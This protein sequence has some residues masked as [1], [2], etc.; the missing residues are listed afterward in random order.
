MGKKGGGRVRIKQV[1]PKNAMAPMNPMQEFM[2]IPPDE[3]IQIPP[4]MD[5]SITNIWPPSPFQLFSASA[6]SSFQYD[7]FACIWPT[8]IDVTK[9][10]KEGRRIRKEEAVDTPTVSDISEVLQGLNVRHAVQPYKGYSRDAESRWFNL[11]R[12]LYDLDQMRE[13]LN[14]GSL[15]LDANNNNN[16]G[17]DIDVDDVPNLN[18]DHD[19]DGNMTQ[20]Q[21]WKYIASKVEGMPGR[22]IRKL[23]EKKTLEDEARK[24]KARKLAASKSNKSSKAASGGGTNKKKG[25]KKR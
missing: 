18:D 10:T 20:K 13:R 22:K 15:V 8:Y 25:K 2:N 21:C 19:G 16:K 14:D 9:T 24:E 6:Q 17:V 12:V 4:K 1:G 7:R 5:T 3:Q 23:E 11:G